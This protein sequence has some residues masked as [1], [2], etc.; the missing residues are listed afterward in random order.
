METQTQ[1]TNFEE[2]LKV[3]DEVVA[4]IQRIQAKEARRMKEVSCIKPDIVG[5]KI[6]QR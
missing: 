3:I 2:S 4:I 5:M 6:Q 1:I